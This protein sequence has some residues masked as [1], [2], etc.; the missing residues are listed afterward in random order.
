MFARIKKEI[1][2]LLGIGFAAA[3]IFGPLWWRPVSPCVLGDFAARSQ[4]QI[5][6]ALK[7]IYFDAQQIQFG[8]GNAAIGHWQGLGDAVISGGVA[9]VRNTNMQSP[10][11]YSVVNNRY[12]QSNAL[13]YFPRERAPDARWPVAQTTSLPQLW[14]AL[15]QKYSNGVLFAGYVQLKPLQLMAIARPP[16]DNRGILKNAPYYYTHPLESFPDVWVYVVGIT[17]GSVATDRSDRSWLAAM[18]S[19]GSGQHAR[20]QG[21]IYGLLLKSAPSDLQAPPKRE[22][23]INVGQLVADS[24][25]VA[26]ELKLYSIMRAGSCDSS[27]RVN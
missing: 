27:I 18:F 16:I 15:T 1:I 24:T 26:G 20:S 23:V 13:L 4:A 9:W 14:D 5:P 7:D 10:K 19:A 25:I 8:F 12:F 3:V 6:E 2:L 22:Q 11:Y 17:P 21:L